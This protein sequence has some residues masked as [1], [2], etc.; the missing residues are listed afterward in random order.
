MDNKYLKKVVEEEYEE[1]LTELQNKVKVYKRLGEELVGK[2]R[3]YLKIIEHEIKDLEEMD[4]DFTDYIVRKG[5]EYDRNNPD[6]FD[7]EENYVEDLPFDPE[8]D[9]AF[10]YDEDDMKDLDLFESEKGK[11]EKEDVIEIDD[12]ELRQEVRNIRRK[13]INESRLKAVIEDE[14]REILAEMKYKSNFKR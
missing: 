5:E 12:N 6:P 8:D 11:K 4:G 13:R 2:E 3:F 7:D 9:P 14:L 1:G 10:G